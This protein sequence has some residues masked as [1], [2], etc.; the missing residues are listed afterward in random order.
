[1]VII[2]S[3]I[4]NK[5]RNILDPSTFNN[6]VSYNVKR[7]WR[8][9]K[10]PVTFDTRLAAVNLR[11]DREIQTIRLQTAIDNVANRHWCFW[12]DS[13]PRTF[14]NLKSAS[15]FGT[16]LNVKHKKSKI[17][18]IVN[19]FNKSVNSSGT[20]LNEFGRYSYIDNATDGFSVWRIM[21][22]KEEPYIDLGR[23][24]AQK[25]IPIT[26]PTMGWL[27]FIYKDYIEDNLP[28][29]RK[30]FEG[31]GYSPSYD[32]N[33]KI[34]TTTGKEY[35][36]HIP[37]DSTVHINLVSRP[38]MSSVLQYVIFKR[39]I[40]WFMRK[41]A[42]KNWMPPLVVTLGNENVQFDYENTDEET[43]MINLGRR[44]AT[45][46][47]FGVAVLKYGE[48]VEPLESR[49]VGKQSESLVQQIRLLDEQIVFGMG[50][51]LGFESVEKSV[52]SGGGRSKEHS[53]IRSV[54]S[55]RALFWNQ[56]EPLY[57]N[58][59]LPAYGYNIELGE[60]QPEWPHTSMDRNLEIA[61][62]VAALYEQRLITPKIAL[63]ILQSIWPLV[64]PNDKTTIAWVE[65]QLKEMNKPAPTQ[66]K[67]NDNLKKTTQVSRPARQKAGAE[68][69]RA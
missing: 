25:V 26:H 48:S 31:T 50:G 20:P 67:A 42:E 30:A 62:M 43:A 36:W 56:L 16:G 64:D 51:S 52:V 29:T 4:V 15:T 18:Q 27:K 1:M 8:N 39:W 9:T 28:T 61:Q 65:K 11:L 44:I 41:C 58:D 40:L 59:L 19:N 53:H 49:T 3:N 12:A 22:I 7:K 46:S 10:V 2:M 33:T 69:K 55:D 34:V 6:E 63:K 45:L 32:E 54:Q 13:T 57:V 47:T 24:N 5:P 60:L 17:E 35:K 14:V 37:S 23:L 68:Q 66:G 38:A 21:K